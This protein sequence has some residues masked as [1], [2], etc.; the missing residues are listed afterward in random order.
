[1]YSPYVSLAKICFPNA[2][3]IFDRFHIVNLISRMLNKTRIKLMNNNKTIY[4]K[5]KRYWKLILM[6][7]EELNYTDYFYSP[8]F[9]GRRTQ[10]IILDW[11]LEQND[12]LK[13]TY[14][15]YQ[16]FLK[17]LKNKNINGLENSIT[18]VNVKSVSSY[19]KT[20]IKTITK[21]LEYI[22]NAAKYKYSNGPIEGI[23]NKI[24]VVKRIS[25]GYR[26]FI[27]LRTRIFLMNNII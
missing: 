23:N 5:L 22:K 12:E 27:N 16:N 9:R 25:F 10:K 13:A 2:Q 20:A 14:R 24:K 3:I 17:S 21:N 6:D 11:L 26:S 8:C 18:N 1:M 4:N 7:E 15:F 19:M